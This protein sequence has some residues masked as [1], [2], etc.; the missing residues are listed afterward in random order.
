MILIFQRI[1]VGYG[2]EKSRR[3]GFNSHPSPEDLELQSY[4]RPG[5][6]EQGQVNSLSL[7]FRI[8]LRKEKKE[9]LPGAGKKRLNL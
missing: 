5:Q 7:L 4:T 8:Y 6:K 1:I 2:T 3:I 9:K